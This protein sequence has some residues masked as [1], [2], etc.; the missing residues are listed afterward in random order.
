MVRRFVYHAL[1]TVQNYYKKSECAN[2]SA[3][4]GYYFMTEI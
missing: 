1:L 3:F 4:Y 2:N